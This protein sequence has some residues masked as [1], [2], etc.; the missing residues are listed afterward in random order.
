MKQGDVVFRAAHRPFGR[1]EAYFDGPHATS[2][3]SIT[4]V[5]A[6]VGQPRENISPCSPATCLIGLLPQAH[7]ISRNRRC[8]PGMDPDASRQTPRSPSSGSPEPHA[9]QGADNL[10]AF[11]HH[12]SIEGSVPAMLRGRE[13]SGALRRLPVSPSTAARFV[14]RQQ[15]T[16]TGWNRRRFP[17]GRISWRCLKPLAGET[18]VLEYFI[19]GKPTVE[20]ACN[21]PDA[22]AAYLHLHVCLDQRTL[23]VSERPSQHNAAPQ[24]AYSGEEANA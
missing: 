11:S 5:T 14:R 6:V 1:K 2:I 15:R 7:E 3:G 8:P 22:I 9:G 21:M 19:S 13:N 16:S 24:F 17:Q 4:A 10:F 23:G 20:A 12:K 18:I